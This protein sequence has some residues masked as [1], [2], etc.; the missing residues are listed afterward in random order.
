MDNAL[1]EPMVSVI[2]PIYNAEKYLDESITSI[3]KQTFSDFELILL[4]GDSTD[5][6]TEICEN[7]AKK[8]VRIRIISQD[9]P[10]LWY[11]RNKGIRNARGRYF[12]ACD[13]DDLYCLDYLEKMVREAEKDEADIVECM[14]YMANEDLSEM[15]VYDGLTRVSDWGHDY[16]ERHCAPSVWKYLVRRSFWNEEKLEYLESRTMADLAMYSLVFSLAKKASYVFEPLYIY[17]VFDDSIS[18]KKTNIETKFD[19][20]EKVCSFITDQFRQRKLFDEKRLVLLSQI[21]NHAGEL[22]SAIDDDSNIGEVAKRISGVIKQNYSVENT[23]FDCG[24]FGWGR[25][26]IER[27]IL[28]LRKDPTRSISFVNDVELF[29]LIDPSLSDELI[30]I[31][32]SNS[33]DFV[34]LD[35]VNE[36]LT[37]RNEIRNASL[38]IKRWAGGSQVFAEA[39]KA[40]G[41]PKVYLLERYLSE[42]YYSEKDVVQFDDI[43]NIRMTNS[44]LQKMYETFAV[45]YANT[46]LIKAIPTDKNI[47]DSGDE[48]IATDLTT[49]YFYERILDKVHVDNKS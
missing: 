8:D 44:I 2:M 36:A 10:N 14:F 35:F 6:S 31:L 20:F 23:L 18:H 46:E 41:E 19:S 39:L 32:Q 4:P 21:E 43:D 27:M 30:G 28:L 42:N 47:A 40:N 33:F 22:Y 24:V 37:I 17:R 26:D 34:V 7:W 11:A 5:R 3:V 48:P 16:I 45:M 13:A 1:R 15:N 12:C 49:Q 9:K 29:N 38:E 25:H